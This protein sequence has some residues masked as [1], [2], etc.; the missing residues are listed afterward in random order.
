MFPAL[1]ADLLR[2]YETTTGSRLR[3]NIEMLRSP[4]VHAVLVFRLRDWLR[5]QTVLFRIALAPVAIFLDYR[6]RSTWGIEIHRGARIGKGLL[7]VHQ[8]G[9][10]ISSQSV[11][12]EN[13]TVAHDV[14]IGTGG[15]GPR[16]GAPIIGDNVTINA[17]AKVYGKIR[18]GNNA[19]IGP[20]AVVNRN[21][22]DNALAHTPP[23][24]IIRFGS[25]YKAEAEGTRE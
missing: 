11:I 18:I 13:F 25:F 17:G 23:T 24:T 2:A 19:R 12:G 22:P 4:M 16:D 1:T 5:H 6:M 9:I 10:F 3:R 7:I 8:G 14:T 20:N 15:K 21:V